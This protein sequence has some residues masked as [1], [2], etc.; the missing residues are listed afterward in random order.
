MPR[1]DKTGP[2]GWGPGTDWGMGPCGAGLAWRRGGG[3]GSGW[4]WFEPYQ[5]PGEKEE[6]EILKEELKDLE[7]E[8]V[9]I[10]ERL[11]QLKDK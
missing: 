8:M 7:D 6:K 10:K 5:P 2:W 11:S 3:R 9:Q 1:Y 4:R